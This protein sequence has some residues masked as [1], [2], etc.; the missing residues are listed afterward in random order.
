MFEDDT[1]EELVEGDHAGAGAKP[2]FCTVGPGVEIKFYGA[3]VASTSTPSAR[4]L[5]DGVSM[6]VPHRSTGPARPRHCREMT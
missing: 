6:L 5:L 2:Q 1:K 4:R 3:F